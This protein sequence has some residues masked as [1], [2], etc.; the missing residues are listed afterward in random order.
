[1]RGPVG[2]AINLTVLREGV[3]E[4]LKFVITRAIITVQSVKVRREGEAKNIG[5]IRVSTFNEQTQAGIEKGI[6]SLKRDGG[7]LVGVILDLRNNPGGLLDQA[8]AVSDDFLEQ[9]QIVSTRGRR[10]RDSQRF[11]SQPGDLVGGLPMIVMINGGSASASEIVAGALQDHKRAVVLGTKS[12]GKGSVQTIIPLGGGTDGALKLT[13]ARY[14][15][16]SGRS[17][18]ATGIEPDIE[19]E[20]LGKDGAPLTSGPSE[21]D[22][23]NH[24]EGEAAAPR[25]ETPQEEAGELPAISELTRPPA[26]EAPEDYQ[27]T[28]AIEVLTGMAKNS[29]QADTANAVRKN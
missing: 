14:F 15:T 1:M 24:L 17:I 18:Q 21:A 12:F 23:R 13:T 9:G 2:T 8:I 3:D 27:L 10:K 22:L 29:A 4:P 6:K 7:D 5:Y 28:R 11:D 26:G 16:P 20:Q 25:A 19:V